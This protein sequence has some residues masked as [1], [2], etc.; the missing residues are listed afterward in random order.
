VWL[1]AEL[2]A[3]ADQGRGT[4]RRLARRVWLGA[5]LATGGALAAGCALPPAPGPGTT[6]HVSD[7]ALEG[8]PARRASLRLV[9]QGLDEDEE[10]RRRAALSSYERAIQLDS[11]NPYA[12]LALA[13]HE[14][15]AAR[16]NR[17]LEALDQA[18]LLF[19]PEGAPGVEAHLAGLRGAAGLAKGYGA[20][21]EAL[22]DRAGSL[23][24]EVWGDGFLTAGELRGGRASR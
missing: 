16:W 22:L 7:A 8:D 19:G 2:G 9:L 4:A 14:V 3:A 10:G 21:A 6:L 13:R 23:A 20:D 24:P 11:T 18:E 1:G 12:Y 17:A 15:E 5:L